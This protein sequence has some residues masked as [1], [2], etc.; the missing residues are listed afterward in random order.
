MDLVKSIAEEKDATPYQIASAWVLHQ[1]G[2]TSPIIGPRTLDHLDDAL[3]ILNIEFTEEDFARIDAIAKPGQM[4]VPYYGADGMAWIPW[5]PHQASLV[6]KNDSI[7][8]RLMG[9]V[10]DVRAIVL[11]LQAILNTVKGLE[12][13]QK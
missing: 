12:Y 3:A 4:T 1:K 11:C 13:S 5:G 7:I 10:L 9:I 8:L 2:I 6:R